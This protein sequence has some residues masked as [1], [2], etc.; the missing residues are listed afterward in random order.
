MPEDRPSRICDACGAIDTHARHVYISDGVPSRHDLV[1]SVIAREDIDPVT[2]ASIV[3]SLLDTELQSRHPECCA[4]QGC[5]AA[6][7]EG[8]CAPLVATGLTG[9][10]L[11]TYIISGG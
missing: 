8:D 9:D 7:L 5:P 3:E 2:R 4:A 10:A 11:L 6:G 1:A